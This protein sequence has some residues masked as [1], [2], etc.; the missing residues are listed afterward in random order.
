MS[1]F[2]KRWAAVATRVADALAVQPGDV[3]E[4]RERCGRYDVIQEL[5][6]AL[7]QRG[8]VPLPQLLPPAYYQRL[9]AGTDPAL[10][11]VWDR[12]RLSWAER[13]ID[14]VLVVAGE[15]RGGDVPRAA[16][17]AWRHAVDRL[18][19]AE[20]RR[21]LPYL[22]MAAPTEA[23]AREC[24]MTLAALEDIVL[25]ALLATPQEVGREIDRVLGRLRAAR[26][27]TIRSAAGELHLT[28][29]A[30]PWL[31]DAGALPVTGVSPDGVQPVNNLP[32]GAVYTTVLEEATHGSIGVPQVAEA[33]DVTLHFASGRVV[34][35]DAAEGKAD[36]EALFARHSGEAR[37]VSHVGIGLNPHLR[38]E[39]GWT[40]VDEHRH[41][42]LLLAMG[43]NRYLGGVN[44]SSLNVDFAL[45]TATLLADSQAIVVDGTLVV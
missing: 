16:R 42:N 39:V 27:L 32:A 13:D 36:L 2:D 45:P 10:L 12:R 8:G 14:R 6:L 20:E 43:E 18:T 3:V 30:R 5:L 23:R 22:L 7:E 17:D 33:R 24:G 25:P 15:E 21:R 38:R 41:G 11:A 19:D 26:T 35:I 44:Q 4:V 1:E 31:S 28:L 40:L 34:A 9:L 29:A 37:R